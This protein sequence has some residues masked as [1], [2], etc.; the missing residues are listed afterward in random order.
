MCWPSNYN[1]ELVVLT[2]ANLLFCHFHKLSMCMISDSRKLI[3]QLNVCTS[4]VWTVK[5]LISLVATPGI[6]G[7]KDT[8]QSPHPSLRPR[9]SPLSPPTFPS[10]LQQPL[11]AGLPPRINYSQSPAAPA[12]ASVTQ[13]GWLSHGG[14]R[15]LSTLLP[16]APLRSLWTRSPAGTHP[17]DPWTV[18]GNNGW[19]NHSNLVSCLFFC[20]YSEFGFMFL[21]SF[22]MRMTKLDIHFV[23]CC[24]CS[25]T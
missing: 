1:L 24:C 12:L 23:S 19:F 21:T 16:T 20:N 4:A 22:H 8:E 2:E 18:L 11:Q 7:L 10:Q 17:H 14:Q 15:W 13:R 9:L 3:S 6:Q 5:A 25:S